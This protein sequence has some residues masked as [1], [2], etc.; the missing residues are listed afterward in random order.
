MEDY[1]C[2]E[3]FDRFGA[4]VRLRSCRIY[5]QH[6]QASDFQAKNA[7]RAAGGRSEKNTER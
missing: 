3:C 5:V 6:L 2:P 1:Y 4:P 7:D